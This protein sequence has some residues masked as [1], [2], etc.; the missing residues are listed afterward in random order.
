MNAALPESTRAAKPSTL[1]EQ[2]YANL[3]RDI[4]SGELA[5]EL[6]LR[7]E[8]LKQ[9]YELSFTPL[10]EALNRL[11]SERLVDSIALKGFRVA[12]LSIKEMHDSMSVRTLIDCE[13]LRR[14]IGR[15]T[16]DWETNIVAALHA[17]DLATRRKGQ[18]DP[19][20]T[21]DDLEQRHLALHRALIAAC[22]SRWLLELSATL[23]V[24]TERYRRPMLK[25]S[26]RKESSR[27]VSKEHHEIVEAALK[28]DVDRAAALLAD[29]YNRTTQLIE[30]SLIQQ[31][32]A[33]ASKQPPQ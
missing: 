10:R 29:H 23:Y 31:E 21:Y 2:A 26:A 33:W 13:A 1:A 19:S 11:H 16:D 17:L 7:L 27:D 12:P 9:R 25:T 20:A 14:S 5:P 30:T 4:L 24:Q 22:D 32:S 15:A 3:K 8:F 6:A 18:G 28:R